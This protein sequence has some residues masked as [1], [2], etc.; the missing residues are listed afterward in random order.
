[1]RA[2]TKAGGKWYES[3]GPGSRTSNWAWW[4]SSNHLSLVS[5]FGYYTLWKFSGY[6]TIGTS[7]SAT[8]YAR[9]TDSNA[10]NHASRYADTLYC[11]VTM[12][13]RSLHGVRMKSTGEQ[14]TYY[15]YN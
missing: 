1:M 8:I 4:S 10:S 7:K 3:D 12:C 15:H 6:D 9:Y 2:V 11:H 13:G 5:N 14:K